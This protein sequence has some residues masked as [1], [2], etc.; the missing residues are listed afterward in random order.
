MLKKR[1]GQVIDKSNSNG[2]GVCEMWIKLF[3][4]N[5][6]H[7]EAKQFDKVMTD[8]EITEAMLKAFPARKNS[9]IFHLVHKVRGRYNRGRLLKGVEPK[10]QSFKYVRNGKGKIERK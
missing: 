3:K 5:E 10:I 7:F 1:Q 6:Q 2:L 9:K 4:E 8:K